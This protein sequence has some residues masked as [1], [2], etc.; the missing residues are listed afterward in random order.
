MIYF[1]KIFMILQQPELF[2]IF[3]RSEEPKSQRQYLQ[4][5]GVF[6]I[7]KED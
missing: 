7:F 3:P 1:E 4:L 5:E 6:V 2:K